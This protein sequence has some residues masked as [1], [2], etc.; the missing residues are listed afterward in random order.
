MH[1]KLLLL[2]VGALAE[3]ENASDSTIFKHYYKELVYDMMGAAK[4]KRNTANEEIPQMNT[5]FKELKKIA[6]NSPI[7]TRNPPLA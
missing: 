3:N 2:A 7:G 5:L 1:P 6:V 4:S